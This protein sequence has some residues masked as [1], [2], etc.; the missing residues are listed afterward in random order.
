MNT[1]NQKDKKK[2]ASLKSIQ[3]L[4]F[5]SQLILIITLA[6]ILGIAGTVINIHYESYVRILM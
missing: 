6:L 2:S 1:A 5:R 4:L 3:Q